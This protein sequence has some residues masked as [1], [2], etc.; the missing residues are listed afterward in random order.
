MCHVARRRCRPNP[1]R[2]EKRRLALAVSDA[3]VVVLIGLQSLATC[4]GVAYRS[5]GDFFIIRRT[6]SLSPSGRP[7]TIRQSGVGSIA[8]CPNSFS[9][10][11]GPGNG[12]WPAHI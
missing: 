5:S 8:W 12:T 2:L 3:G 10:R 4:I 9:G 6:I 7:G 1:Q 11:L